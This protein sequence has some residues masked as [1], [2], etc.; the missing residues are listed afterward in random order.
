MPHLVL[1]GHPP[2][3]D[4]A[5]RLQPG[6]LRWGRAVLKTEGCWL[7]AKGDALLVEGVVVELSRPLHPVALV[8]GHDGHTSVRLWS[9]VAV[10]RTPAVQRWLATLAVQLQALGV[11]ALQSTNIPD[12]LLADL[13]LRRTV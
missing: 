1:A 9:R 8:T 12:E 5:A 10:E 11:G 6:V 13:A 3:A 7:H 4:L 2:L